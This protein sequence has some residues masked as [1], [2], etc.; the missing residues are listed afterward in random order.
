MSGRTSGGQ[1]Q[2]ACFGPAARPSQRASLP[3]TTCPNL[4]K[5]TDSIDEQPEEESLLNCPSSSLSLSSSLA[6]EPVANN[7]DPACVNIDTAA[8]SKRAKAAATKQQ[9]LSSP[10]KPKKFSLQS[11]SNS[12]SSSSSAANQALAGGRCLLGAP[13]RS[14][15]HSRAYSPPT[16]T[17]S[18][19]S[20]AFAIRQADERQQQQVSAAAASS[21]TSAQLGKPHGQL[22]STQTQTQSQE[23]RAS[24]QPVYEPKHYLAHCAPIQFIPLA[25]GNQSNQAPARHSSSNSSSAASGWPPLRSALACAE[26]PP[27]GLSASGFRRQC[28]LT[29]SQS[30]I[31]LEFNCPK[32]SSHL[33]CTSL[34]GGALIASCPP[35]QRPPLLP[36][37]PAQQQQQASQMNSFPMY[38]FNQQR[39]PSLRRYSTTGAAI[40]T[41]QPS[42]SSCL[43]TDAARPATTGAPLSHRQRQN[44][45]SR[46]AR[47]GRK[48]SVI[49]LSCA[50]PG[51]FSHLHQPAGSTKQALKVAP[52]QAKQ[53]ASRPESTRRHTLAD[54]SQVVG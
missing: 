46:K 54:V 50:P 22:K 45:V 28:S 14:H 11:G 29:S 52:W 27:G 36:T 20:A 33:M 35:G 4:M 49:G 42:L 53:A 32:C 12:S 37:D 19:E 39:R 6:A 18:N 1:K 25:L 21:E 38:N 34:P 8:A 2:S 3:L 30:N 43:E 23:Y 24:L 48:L 13:F 44:S 17:S 9:F 15:H 10:V 51:C 40:I 16:T 41:Q 7:N 5:P 26:Y 47:G 31:A